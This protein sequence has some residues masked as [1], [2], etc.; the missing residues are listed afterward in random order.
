MNRS[1]A[2]RFAA[3]LLL[4]FL[5]GSLIA[6]A[7]AFK[8]N[9]FRASHVRD[10]DS[11]GIPKASRPKRV[12]R[13]RNACAGYPLKMRLSGRTVTLPA[14]GTWT[15][16]SHLATGSDGFSRRRLFPFSSRENIGPHLERSC[17]ELMKMY[18]GDYCGSVYNNK[19]KRVWTPPENG[20][21][22]QGSV[23]NRRP[24]VQEEMWI[25]NMMWTG[26][27]MPP[28]G[29]KFLASYNGRHVVVVGGY[30][31]GPSSRRF[32]GGFQGEVF[33]A[34]GASEGSSRITLRTLEDQ[35]LAP[36]PIACGDL[37]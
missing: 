34:L 26:K 25:F 10:T 21:A 7:E 22:G 27:S 31:R 28:P 12:R 32:L 29:T 15:L 6:P 18:G 13:G 30:E 2:A 1:L 14:A 8:L 17:R 33:W 24:S 9:F 4:P 35:S 37:E 16:E 19:W 3:C 23:G 5:L 20:K 36:G 11:A